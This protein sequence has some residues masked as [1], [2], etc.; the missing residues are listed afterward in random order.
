MKTYPCD[1]SKTGSCRHGG[2]KTYSFGIMSGLA[3]YCRHPDERKFTDDM[4]KCPLTKQTTA[5]AEQS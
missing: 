1:L 5:G 3:G 4:N 2:N